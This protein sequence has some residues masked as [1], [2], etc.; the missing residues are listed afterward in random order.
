MEINNDFAG[1]SELLDKANLPSPQKDEVVATVGRALKDVEA[2]AEI[3]AKIKLRVGVSVAILVFF[4]ASYV[5]AYQFISE[6]LTTEK[7]LITQ[8]LLDAK[9]RSINSATVAALIAAT[10]TQTG[11][12]LYAVTKYLFGPG[13]PEVKEDSA[14]LGTTAG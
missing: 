8:K 13:A 1:L 7:A 10:V 14:S 6:I 12:A 3:K 5:F 2:R 4:A 11:F 9:D